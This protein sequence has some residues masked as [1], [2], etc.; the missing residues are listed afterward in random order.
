MVDQPN[1]RT[2]EVGIVSVEVPAGTFT[3]MRN[4]IVDG[5]GFDDFFGCGWPVKP[6]L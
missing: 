4:R 5:S 6:R 3:T 1:V 2:E